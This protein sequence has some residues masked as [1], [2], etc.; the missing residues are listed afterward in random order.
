M[1]YRTHLSSCPTDEKKTQPIS[2]LAIVPHES[3]TVTDGSHWH[4]E[5]AVEQQQVA[6]FLHR[7]QG[8]KRML[9][10]HDLPGLRDTLKT[11]HK[12]LNAE[13]HAY[14]STRGLPVDTLD[15]WIR[16]AKLADTCAIVSSSPLLQ[17]VRQYGLLLRYAWVDPDKRFVVCVLPG[18]Q[19]AE[20]MFTHQTDV[21][22]A[23][24]VEALWAHV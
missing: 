17:A 19:D 9:L 8:L 1:V 7:Q 14:C 20:R 4:A 18:T 10:L 23:L 2:L 15:M 16:G 5:T 21:H 22:H 6:D 12:A 3:D 13:F 24:L 11:H